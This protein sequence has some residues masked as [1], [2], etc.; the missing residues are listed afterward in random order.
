MRRANQQAGGEHDAID[1]HIAQQRKQHVSAG[2]RW[3]HRLGGAQHAIDGPGLAADLG[4]GPARHHGDEPKRRGPHQGFEE[5]D[6]VVQFAAHAKPKA[7]R[8]QR[9]HQKA[10]PHHDAEGK[11]WD[12]NWRP[13]LAREF[14]E[15]RHHAIDVVGED[16]TA[17]QRHLDG[18]AVCLGLLVGNGEQDERR[19]RLPVPVRL[20][21][22]Q[23]GGLMMQR[24]E[25]L[26]VTQEYLQRHQHGQKPQ[27]HGQN[28]PGFFT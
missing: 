7:N 14:L 23:L 20:N 16:E 4:G 24:V 3:R 10:H 9:Q 13:V 21:G 5:P 2:Q 25:T 12:G 6:R 19:A 27:R 8:H 26:Q 17:Q 22:G 11:E 28:Q 18:I 15:A 1:R